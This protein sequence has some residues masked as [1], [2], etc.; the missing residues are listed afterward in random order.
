MQ[1]HRC[2]VIYSMNHWVMAFPY[3]MYFAYVGTCSS[4]PDAGGDTLLNTTDVVLGIANIYYSSALR[5]LNVTGLNIITSYNSICLAL[6]VLLTLMI[7]VRLIVH[8]RNVRKATETLE[9]SSGHT[10]PS[11]QSSR[12]LLSLMPFTLAFF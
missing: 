3:L 10:Q 4:P 8:I 11:P 6:N 7:V 1:L 9:G 12:C 5:F 2:Y